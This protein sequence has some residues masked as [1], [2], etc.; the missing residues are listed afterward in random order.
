MGEQHGPGRDREPPD[1]LD[2]PAW[3]FKRVGVE[4]LEAEVSRLTA[5][6]ESDLDRLRR[7]RGDARP[8]EGVGESLEDR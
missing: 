7:V 1:P 6:L 3:R 4:A 5:E 2:P 8:S